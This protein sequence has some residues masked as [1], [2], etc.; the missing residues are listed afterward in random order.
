[1]DVLTTKHKFSLKG[2]TDAPIYYHLGCDYFREPAGTMYYG[3]Y[4][5][6][7]ADSFERL[8]GEKS[9]HYSSPLEPG[10]HPEVDSSSL[11]DLRWYLAIPISDWLRSVGCAVG[12]T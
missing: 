2:T 3:T 1:V 8:F 5:G 4:I 7:L 10:D 12:E 9:R 11:L 6:K